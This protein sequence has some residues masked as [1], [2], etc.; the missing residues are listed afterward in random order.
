MAINSSVEYKVGLLVRLILEAL[1]HK[2]NEIKY[3]DKDDIKTECTFKLDETNNLAELFYLNSLIS[4][5][6]PLEFLEDKLLK[7]ND[8]LYAINNEVDSKEFNLPLEEKLKVISERI[9]NQKDFFKIT[10][11]DYIG[12]LDEP[13]SIIKII[14]NF[15]NN[16]IIVRDV[17]NDKEFFAIPAT[18]KENFWYF[19]DYSTDAI[20][21]SFPI[22][23][24]NENENQ[25]GEITYKI[26]NSNLED[27]IFKVDDGFLLDGYSNNHYRFQKYQNGDHFNLGVFNNYN[28]KELC[29]FSLCIT[30]NPF[31]DS[32]DSNNPLSVNRYFLPT[33]I[34]GMTSEEVNLQELICIAIVAMMSITHKEIQ[35][36]ATNMYKS[37]LFG[38]NRYHIYTTMY[39]MQS[40]IIQNNF[41]EFKDRDEIKDIEHEKIDEGEI[42]ALDN[43]EDQDLTEFDKFFLNAKR[44]EDNKNK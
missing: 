34:M 7:S 5:E 39:E 2:P 21:F 4:T 10:N 29:R 14:G 16:K 44:T 17:T 8:F 33:L 18:D 26:K 35:K 23:L 11:P 19:I 31:I 37:M 3:L 24:I 27:C 1:G 38:K 12:S 42:E 20:D 28:G 36:W 30:T 32:F 25:P 6:F 13:K 40:Y 43:E 9:E 41:D 22:I 15:T